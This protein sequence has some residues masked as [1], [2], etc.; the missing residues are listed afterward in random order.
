MKIEQKQRYERLILL[1]ILILA[2]SL[3]FIPHLHYNYPLHI[4]E[5]IHCAKSQAVM[6]CGNITYIDPYLGEGIVST[7][8]EIG[9]HIFLGSFK[10][11]TG[12]PWVVIFKYAPSIIFLFTVLCV[13][14]FARREG[15]GLEA[16]F[17]T[18]LIPTTVR[19]L[20]PAFLVPVALGL[21]F[22]PLML[23]LAFNFRKSS[24][25]PLF[26]LY[27]FLFLMHAATAVAVSV[28]L[29]FYAIA[30]LKRKENRKHGLSIILIIIAP[31]LMLFPVVYP[32]VVSTVESFLT[33]TTHWLPYVTKIFR[34]YG[35]IPSI[36]FVIGAFMLYA[37]AR[38]SDYSLV[39][40]SLSFLL[41]IVTFVRVGY[42]STILYDRIYMYL[43]ILMSI[44]AGYGLNMIR[45]IPKK[46]P[47]QLNRGLLFN[48]LLSVISIAAYFAVIV[49]VLNASINAHQDTP[50]YHVIE[51]GE[52]NDFIWIKENVNDSY[53][54]AIL[55][56]W[57][58]IAF[59]PITEK[60]VYSRTFQGPN[61]LYGHRHQEVHRF[62][63]HGCCDTNF[64]KDNNIS[65]VYATGRCSNS[66]LVNVKK[67]IY[68]VKEQ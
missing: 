41:L 7:D 10:E 19:L 64:L 6:V 50:Y 66:D 45:N 1:A 16:A 47:I 2:S 34:I 63:S 3:A 65:I 32:L 15:Y 52:Y 58:A 28:I 39:L 40:A 43:M 27:L 18:C 9:Y 48:K 56:P 35:I 14:V 42:G 17:F 25:L 62:F 20:G 11:I 60:Y 53:S 13:Y 24:Y 21:A 67:N 51:E 54:R 44:I 46:I 49:L 38:I 61:P 4:D 29:L 36:I 59:A 37:R 5:W 30:M 55:H 8:L 68:L 33:P 22:I 31:Y 57:K 26:I 23:Y 12:I